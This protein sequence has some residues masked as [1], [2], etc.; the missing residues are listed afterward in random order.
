LVIAALLFGIGCARTFALSDYEECGLKGM[1]LEGVRT[2]SEQGQFQ[3]W[4]CG[5]V[6][7]QVATSGQELSSK[8]P[9]RDDRGRN[10][11][12]KAYAAKATYK[13]NN[14][15]RSDAALEE[16]GKAAVAEWQRVYRA[17]MTGPS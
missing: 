10:C 11:E 15:R 8:V 6:P 3:C 13:L 16:V 14:Q 7:G 5:P 9:P 12:V 2:S 17:C 1:E 4:G